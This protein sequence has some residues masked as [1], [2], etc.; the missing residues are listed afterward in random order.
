MGTQLIFG[1]TVEVGGVERDVTVTAFVQPAEKRTHTYPGCPAGAEVSATFDDTHG[2][3]PD[4]VIE[5]HAEE[6]ECEAL[7][8]T[9]RHAEAF[10][11]AHEVAREEVYEARRKERKM[12]HH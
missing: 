6:W 2:E 10:R 3:V 5:E 9:D 1:G 8:E 12:A 7:E 11:E 4:S